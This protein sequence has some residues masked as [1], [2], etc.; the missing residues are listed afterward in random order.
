MI[1]FEKNEFICISN[2]TFYLINNTI[3]YGNNILFESYNSFIIILLLLLFIIVTYIVY[4]I[5]YCFN[6]INSYKY[7]SIIKFNSKKDDNNLID[8]NL[9]DNNFIT[10][11][12]LIIDENNELND[13]NDLKEFIKNEIKKDL[14]SFNSREYNKMKLYNKDE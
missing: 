2:Q 4:F 7:Y 13:D 6:K 8:N 3:C 9:I 11:N 5:F 12:D 14:N 10:S 1:I